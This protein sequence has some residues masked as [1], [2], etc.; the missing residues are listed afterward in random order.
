MIKKIFLSVILSFIFIN[1]TY[2][3]KKITYLRCPLMMVENKG[4]TFTAPY[5]KIGDEM[6]EVYAKIIETKKTKISMYSYY[7]SQDYWIDSKPNNEEGLLKNL[8]FTKD[9]NMF[10]WSDAFSSKFK[11]QNT[12]E[13]VE[14]SYSRSYKFKND[15][16]K[17][18]LIFLE[19]SEF[20]YEESH[21]RNIHIKHKLGGDCL[22]IDKKLYKDF[23]KNGKV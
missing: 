5:W 8:V 11:D 18:N 19:Y 15:N 20:K 16:N 23:I 10:K 2:A 3:A 4:K 17:W 21:S 9:K 7:T 1:T 14:N 6:N 22:T 13:M 12:K